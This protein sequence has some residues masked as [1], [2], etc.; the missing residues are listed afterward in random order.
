MEK[1][2]AISG[3]RPLATTKSE[4]LYLICHG[5]N[6]DI[7]E[8]SRFIC[9]TQTRNGMPLIQQWNIDITSE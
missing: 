3:H 4:T 1:L 7:Q 8:N 9:V 5:D 6:R 2:V